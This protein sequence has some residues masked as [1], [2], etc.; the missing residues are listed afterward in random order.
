VP[1]CPLEKMIAPLLFLFLYCSGFDYCAVGWGF[2]RCALQRGGDAYVGGMG[3]LN[4]SVIASANQMGSEHET[5]CLGRISSISPFHGLRRG[6]ASQ[7][8][9]VKWCV[10]WRGMAWHDGGCSVAWRLMKVC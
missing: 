9:T 7:R 10:A 2:D 3:S 1:L 6:I 4:T 5:A 8:R